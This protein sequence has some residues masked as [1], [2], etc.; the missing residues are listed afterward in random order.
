MAIQKWSDNIWVLQ[1]SDDR[2]FNEEVE[3]AQGQI[4]QEQTTPD[5][6]VDLSGVEHLN[7]SNLSQLLKLRKTMID[8]D[9]RLRLASPPD[10]VWALF[11]TTGLDKV[12]DFKS[13]TSTALADLQI[14][15]K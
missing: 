11:L 14:G 8:H 5:V 2:I 4:E 3:A 13:D 1:L 15:S 12:F 6:V 7:S 10:K 9:A